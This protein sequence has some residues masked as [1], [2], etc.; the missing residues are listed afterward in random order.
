MK[1]SIG[2]VGLPNVGKSTLFKALTKQEVKIANYP[3]VT[4]D[5][6]IG[7][8][9]IPDGRLGKIA[10]VIGSKEIFPAVF[11]FVDIAGLVR[12]AHQGAGLGNQFLARIREVDAIVHLVRIFKNTEIVHFENEPNPLRDFETV[13]E[14]LKL[15]D[16]QSKEKENLLSKKPQLIILNGKLEEV[17]PD[18]INKINELKFPNL[19]LDLKDITVPAQ[20]LSDILNAFLK[21]LDLVVFYTANE[22]EARSWL[23]KKGTKAP[24]AAGVVHTDFEKKFIKAEAINW[25]KL[26]EGGSWTQTKQKGWLRLEGKDYVVQ[27]GDV[28][29]IRHG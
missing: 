16:E 5:P 22:N 8:V 13:L 25:Q 1:L 17:P 15:K 11:E 6:N 9:G 7:V 23:V 12:G 20:W 29:V 4:I 21:L 27:D 18:L 28:M 10:K 3:F 14:E 19:I 24:Q 2:I 26:L